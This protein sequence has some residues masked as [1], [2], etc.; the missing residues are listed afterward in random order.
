MGAR[1]DKHMVQIYG[2]AIG[3][4][5]H[6]HLVTATYASILIHDMNACFLHVRF[7]YKLSYTVRRHS[8]CAAFG[9]S[10]SIY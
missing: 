9:R 7:A 2:G 5:H 10:I 6:S 3:T 1:T 8:R 4:S